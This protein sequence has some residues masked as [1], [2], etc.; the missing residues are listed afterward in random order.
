[1]KARETSD[2]PDELSDAILVASRA[3]VAIAARSMPDGDEVTLAQYRALVVLASHGAIT[4]GRLSDL[5]EV[6]PSTVTRLIDRLEAKGFVA[7][8]GSDD[9]R[10]VVVDLEPPAV[11]LLAAVTRGRRRQIRRVVAR[12]APD[13]RDELLRAFRAFADAAGEIPDSQWS[14][15]LDSPVPASQRPLR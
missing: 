15:V 13:Q 14:A 11:R 8:S 7:R 12:V 4:A 5:L 3:L 9:R 1:M 2:P 10:E 6:H